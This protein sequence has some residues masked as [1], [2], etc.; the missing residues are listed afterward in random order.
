[1]EKG[2][3]INLISLARAPLQ[4][5]KDH[6]GMTVI[7]PILPTPNAESSVTY[8]LAMDLCGFFFPSKTQL[9]F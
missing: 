6:L 8:K 2:Y 7:G 4:T 9:L 5:D 1:M 3:N